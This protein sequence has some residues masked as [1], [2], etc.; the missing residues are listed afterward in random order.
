MNPELLIKNVSPRRRHAIAVIVTIVCCGLYSCLLAGVAQAQA[1]AHAIAPSRSVQAPPPMQVEVYK[2]VVVQGTMPI[3]GAVQIEGMLPS[4][5]A[6]E[7]IDVSGNSGCGGCGTTGGGF[8]G[9]IWEVSTRRMSCCFSTAA[10]LNPTFD[11]YHIEQRRFVSRSFDDM[12][13]AVPATNPQAGQPPLTILYAHGNWMEESN[14]RERIQTIEAAISRYAQQPFRIVL[15]SWPSERERRLLSNIRDNAQCA[16]V[17][18][19]YLNFIMQHFGQENRVSLLGFSFG[20]RVVTG[21]L[22][23]AAGGSINGHSAPYQSQQN[24]GVDL[25]AR[26]NPLGLT[27]YR[28]SL[29]APA[30][31]RSWLETNGRF[32]KATYSIDWMVNL[33]N[34]QDP[35]LRRF[36]FLNRVTAP[37][38]AGFL[39]FDGLLDPRA[40]TPLSS[41]ELI[42][43]FDCDSYV[44][45]HDEKTY[46]G[47]CPYFRKAILNLLWQEPTPSQTANLPSR[48]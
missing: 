9:D 27:E 45:S 15:L 34:S 11:V 42:E 5:T 6:I 32:G 19:Q 8:R 12:L 13:A 33:Y 21:A 48:G 7:S 26:T 23:L 40:T 10:I 43:Q 36:R 28:V 20:G 4:G 41:G 35:V 47:S 39:G 1:A 38:A 29:V 30:V 3:A 24:P 16:D 37:V 22:H 17:Q 2:P 46:Y 31:D 18:A 44:D 14:A 25:G